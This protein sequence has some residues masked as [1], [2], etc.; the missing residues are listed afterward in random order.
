MEASVAE[1]KGIFT[2]AVH[3]LLSPETWKSAEGALTTIFPGAP[4][5]FEPDK[6]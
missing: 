1:V 6:L 5:K 4:V 2:D 3:V